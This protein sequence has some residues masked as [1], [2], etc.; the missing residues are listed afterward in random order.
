MLY[1]AHWNPAF[2]T[3]LVQAERSIDALELEGDVR[4]GAAIVRGALGRPLYWIAANAGY[5]GRQVVERV[6]RSEP[7]VGF[8]AITGEFGDMFD[9][10]S[11]T[12][13]R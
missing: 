3:T 10:G 13:S 2:G 5:D 9:R 6:R 7:A 1:D 8:D 11:S 12:R 4:A